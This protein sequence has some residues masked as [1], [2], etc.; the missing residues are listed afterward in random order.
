MSDKK[1]DLCGCPVKVV[2]KTTLHYEID[3]AR[4]LPSE[5]E[6]EVAHGKNPYDLGKHDRFGTPD[7][8]IREGAWDAYEWLVYEIR[9]RLGASLEPHH[10]PYTAALDQSAA[11]ASGACALRCAST[12]ANL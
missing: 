6:F 11:N 10:T 2:G 8:R 9:K 3:L 4:L 5:Q 12:N 7:G 1:C